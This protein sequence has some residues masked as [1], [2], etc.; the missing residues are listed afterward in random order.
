MN[1]VEHGLGR[2]KD[3]AEGPDSQADRDGQQGD[4]HGPQHRVQARPE[5]ADDD[6]AASVA[7]VSLTS[8]AT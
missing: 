4:Q 2:E 3:P 5:P 8:G 1:E 7:L 6:L